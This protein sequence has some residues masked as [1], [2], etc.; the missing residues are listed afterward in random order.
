MSGIKGMTPWNKGT[1]G[2]KTSK[3]KGQCDNTGITHFKIG[4]IPWNKGKHFIMSEEHKQKI[5][6]A[7]KGN[8]SNVGKKHTEEWKKKRK[9]WCV[10]NKDILKKAGLKGSQTLYKRNPTKLEIE[11]K[12]KLDCAG[13]KHISQYLINNRF[14]VDEYLPEYNLIIEVDGRY[15]HNLDKIVKKDK[16]ENAYLVKCGYRIIRIPENK[17]SDFSTASLLKRFNGCNLNIIKREVN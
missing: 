8:K 5:S 1:T 6:E 10:K 3:N 17:V 2:Y 11:I 16:A 12:N 13:I 14:C 15:W 9:E 4:H 7:N